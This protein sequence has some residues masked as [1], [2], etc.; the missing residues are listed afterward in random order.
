MPAPQPAA[1]TLRIVL[2]NSYGFGGNNT[3][4]VLARAEASAPERI[5]RRHRHRRREPDRLGPRRRSGA[6]CAPAA[7]GIAA[8]RRAGARP[9]GRPTLAAAVRDFARARL[10]P[11]RRY[12]RRMDRCR[13][14][15]RRRAA[16][17]ST[18]PTRARRRRAAERAGIVVGSA[19]G[20]LS[21][22]ASTSTAGSSPKGPAAREPDDLP[23]SRA[24]RAG[25][26]RGDR[27]R[28]QRRQ[29][30]RVRRPRR[31]ARRRSRSPSTPCGAGA[32]TSCSPAAATSSRRC[33]VRV[34]HRRPAALAGRPRR[35]G[36]EQPLRSRPER[37]RH[38]RGRGDAGARAA[39]A[40]PPRAARRS[41][42]ASPA[43]RRVPSRRR[44]TTG[45]GAPPP[46]S[47]RWPRC[48]AMRRSS[49]CAAAPTRRPASTP[50]SSTSLRRCRR[51]A[52]R[53]R[54]LDQG[55]R[56]ASSAPPAR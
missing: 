8:A 6:R 31:R 36:V 24:Q 28:L 22:S 34:L 13:D 7:R 26:L 5:R 54:D 38:R 46:P 55:R 23:Q 56:S 3:S 41:M 40:R 17:R 50:A 11:P 49:W 29:P 33:C 9:S 12:Y 1:P 20:D 2:S 10:H 51:R 19:L 27:A 48:V 47:N 45:R 39:R 37:H 16:W 44:A 14:D 30:H 53:P 18:T 52:L 35:R 25:Q 42:R 32:P 4:V 43:A 15:R 21:E